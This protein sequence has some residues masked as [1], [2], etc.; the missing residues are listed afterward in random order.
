MSQDVIRCRRY[1]SRVLVLPRDSCKPSF[2]VTVL[3][4]YRLGSQALST[5]FFDELS[6]VFEC[7]ATSGCPV[8]VCGDFNVHVDNCNTVLVGAP[9]S[10]SD[11]L[12]RVLNAAARVVT[13]TRKFDRGLSQLLH[14][15]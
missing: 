11:K 2:R 14:A 8:V 10:V 6:A 1:N 4:V 15:D 13:G 12:H 9:K 3:A 7:I 5:A